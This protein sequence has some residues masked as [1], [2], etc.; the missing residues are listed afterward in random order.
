MLVPAEL[1]VGQLHPKATRAARPGFPGSMHFNMT[2]KPCHWSEV[3]L[4]LLSASRT[5]SHT[6]LDFLCSLGVAP[7]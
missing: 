4:D 2:L 6:F 3:A 5:P 1:L 7:R